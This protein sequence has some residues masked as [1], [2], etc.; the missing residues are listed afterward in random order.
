MI[1]KAVAKVEVRGEGIPTC[2]WTKLLTFVV[3]RTFGNDAIFILL[4]RQCPVRAADHLA[5][6]RST[7]NQPVVDTL[8]I[9]FDGDEPIGQHVPAGENRRQSFRGRAQGNTT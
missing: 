8:R 5:R 6:C 3:E 9:F 7:L 1:L 2:P 4:Q